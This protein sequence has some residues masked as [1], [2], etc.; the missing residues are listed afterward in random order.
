[1]IKNERKP[2]LADIP[3]G[4]GC[5]NGSIGGGTSNCSTET[6]ISTGDMRPTGEKIPRV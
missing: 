6:I 1:M 3:D 5:S 4:D 2:G